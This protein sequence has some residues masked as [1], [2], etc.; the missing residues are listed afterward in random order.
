[1]SVTAGTS[2]LHLGRQ[3]LVVLARRGTSDYQLLQEVPG[4]LTISPGQTDA[5]GAGWSAGATGGAPARGELVLL[6]RV[7][8]ADG[9][10]L[11]VSLPLSVS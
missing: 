8:L 11:E 5:G 2:E 1:M 6:G 9:S 10:V 4:T 3:G 7:Y